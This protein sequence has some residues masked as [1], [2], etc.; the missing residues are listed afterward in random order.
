MVRACP[1]HHGTSRHARPTYTQRQELGEAMESGYLT[2]LEAVWLEVWQ[3]EFDADTMT[4]VLTQVQRI[5][6]ARQASGSGP[7][8]HEDG[9][10]W[11]EAPAPA[12]T[13]ARARRTYTPRK[14]RAR[15]D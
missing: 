14:P 1:N 3:V 11:P 9:W 4:K 7:V 2:H 5:V 12:P 15:H 13:P 10:F 8:R 6:S